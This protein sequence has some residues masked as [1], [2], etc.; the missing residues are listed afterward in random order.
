[1]S[2]KKQ[3][4]RQ[5]AVNAVKGPRATFVRHSVMLRQPDKTTI[6]RAMTQ[7]QLAHFYRTGKLPEA[8]VKQTEVKNL[9]PSREGQAA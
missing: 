1:M 3:S 9:L 2:K 4:T 6:E 7:A 5:T 8:K